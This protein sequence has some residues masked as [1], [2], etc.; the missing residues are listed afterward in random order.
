MNWIKQNPFYVIL[1]VLTLLG[2]VGTG[3]FIFQARSAYDTVSSDYDDQARELLRLQALK[4]FPDA[5]NQEKLVLDLAGY[6]EQ[7]VGLRKQL[8]G[9]NIPV[10]PTTPG[11]FQQLLL[12][13]VNRVKKEARQANVEIPE[14]F[15]L[16]FGEYENNLPK[17]EATPGLLRQLIAAEKLVKLMIG[18]NVV[19]ITG[20]ARDAVPAERATSAAPTP[21]P[22][23]SRRP[24]R[25]SRGKEKE[26]AT[27]QVA[28]DES[29]VRYGFDIAFTGQH[30]AFQSILNELTQMP[31]FFVVRGV[32]VRNERPQAPLRGAAAAVGLLSGQSAF[33]P[34]GN[35]IEPAFA[36][37]DQPIE[38]DEGGAED[39]DVSSLEFVL[40]REKIDVVMRIELLQFEPPQPAK[41]SESKPA[42]RNN[43]SAK[44]E[45]A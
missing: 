30:A 10:Q 22:T 13:T 29:I 7:T 37:L 14:G 9:F 43:R 19:K 12:D 24:R 31:S 16:G 39:N 25:P 33:G 34:D 2:C 41:A 38:G 40:G 26:K 42:T 44:E 5:E 20:L 1:G 6:Q 28:E 35:P 21:T 45:E 8:E 27:P 11:E 4:P 32:Q 23:P 3:V 18:N 36:P 15:F 17:N